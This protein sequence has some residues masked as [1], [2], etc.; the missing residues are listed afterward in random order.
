MAEIERELTVAIVAAEGAAIDL[1]QP[2][3]AEDHRAAPVAKVRSDSPAIVARDTARQHR[4]VVTVGAD[5]A[6]GP[7]AEI[8][9]ALHADPVLEARMTAAID[10]N[11][12]LCAL[13]GLKSLAGNGWS[14]GADPTR[15][16]CKGLAPQALPSLREPVKEAGRKGAASSLQP[17]AKGAEMPAARPQP[18]PATGAASQARAT[19][20]KSDSAA[21]DAPGG[22]QN[23]T[24]E[25]P[26]MRKGGSASVGAG[27]PGGNVPANARFVQIGEFNADGVTAAVAAIRAMG[28][29]V[30]RQT[31][32]NSQGQRI[33]VAGP[34]DNRERLIAALDR[35]RRAGYPRAF[36]R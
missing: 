27:D 15:G 28:Y 26:A 11:A 20:A 35:L 12:R 3:A 16:Y 1:T 25:R 32:P 10:P 17:A 30:A 9:R 23:A 5:P 18:S 21:A 22:R 31:K 4:A 29:P 24:A 8:A 33:I 14:V 7:G 19:T 36:A 13:L 34:F 6:T 2:T